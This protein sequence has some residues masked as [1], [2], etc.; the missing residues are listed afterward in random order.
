MLLPWKAKI[1]P[2]ATAYQY[3]VIL[4]PMLREEGDVFSMSSTKYP[5]MQLFV[6]NA[7]HEELLAPY[8]PMKGQWRGQGSKSQL[9]HSTF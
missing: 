7:L 3:V 9:L 1:V 2:H 6:G 5:E 8:C 4:I